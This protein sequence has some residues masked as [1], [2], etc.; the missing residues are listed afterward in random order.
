MGRVFEKQSHY[1]E[2]VDLA[3]SC[4]TSILSKNTEQGQFDNLIM[5]ESK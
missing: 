1:S 4:C 5:T 2:R 3:F